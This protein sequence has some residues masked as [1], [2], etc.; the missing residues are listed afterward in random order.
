MRTLWI[1]GNAK[2]IILEQD[3]YVTLVIWLIVKLSPPHVDSDIGS[4]KV[5]WGL[6]D[7]C[8]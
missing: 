2:I 8:S 5:I 1:V 4:S 3:T 6:E 7:W